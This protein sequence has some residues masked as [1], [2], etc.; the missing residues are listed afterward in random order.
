MNYLFVIWRN[1]VPL[2]QK[3]MRISLCFRNVVLEKILES[4][5]DCKEIKPVHPKGNQPWIFIGRTSVKANAPIL[6]PSDVK[7]WFIGKDPDAGKDWRQEEKGMIED[8]M[9]G[10]YHQLSGHE[11]KQTGRWW[12]TGKP[13]LLQVMGSPRVSHDWVTEPHNKANLQN[14]YNLTYIV[15]T[16]K[17]TQRNLWNF[18]EKHRNVFEVP[19]VKA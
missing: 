9:V 1:W 16:V 14:G 19:Y 17:T 15:M 12:R 8:K 10:W 4:P 18:Q 3:F 6:W 13:G 7:S 2:L 5:L 11:F